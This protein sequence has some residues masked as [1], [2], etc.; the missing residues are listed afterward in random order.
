MKE[1]IMSIETVRRFWNRAR[2][3]AVAAVIFGTAGSA[4][5]HEYLGRADCCA[6]GAACC[7]PGAACC[8]GKQLAQR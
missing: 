1:C 6:S 3:F 4:V 2:P 8:H 5:A 7:K